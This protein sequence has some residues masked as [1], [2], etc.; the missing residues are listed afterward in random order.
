LSENLCCIRCMAAYRFSVSEVCKKPRI[1]LRECDRLLQLG[2]AGVQIAFDHIRDTELEMR[3]GQLR[4]VLQGSAELRDGLF[5]LTSFAVRDGNI[6]E[7]LNRGGVQ[8]L[9]A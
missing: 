2:D 8:L 7:R 1:S 4:T 9:C 5:V 3:S 6:Q